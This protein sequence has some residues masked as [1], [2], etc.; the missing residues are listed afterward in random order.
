MG[1]NRRRP[2]NPDTNEKLFSALAATR[3]G[4]GWRRG[5]G[6][7]RHTKK[8]SRERDLPNVSRV[9]CRCEPCRVRMG[10]VG[11]G[12]MSVRG[13]ATGGRERKGGNTPLRLCAPEQMQSRKAPARDSKKV[14]GRIWQ[15]GKRHF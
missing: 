12:E 8:V 2:V 10:N 1:G 15:P 4:P 3:E 7:G 13:E 14:Q 5:R 6:R 9:C 11:G